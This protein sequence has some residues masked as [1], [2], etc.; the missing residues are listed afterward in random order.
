[1]G[2]ELKRR[3]IDYSFDIK[4]FWL[5][6]ILGLFILVGPFIYVYKIVIASTK[7]AEHYN[8]NGAY[9]S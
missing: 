2:N 1:M 5:Y 8:T 3:W 9:V 6:F 7:L 4:D